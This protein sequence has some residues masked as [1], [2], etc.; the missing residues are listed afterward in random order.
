MPKCVNFIEHISKVLIEKR[1]IK[2]RDFKE[3]DI[4]ENYKKVTILHP[5]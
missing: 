4:V 5:H 3:Q 1:E 2:R